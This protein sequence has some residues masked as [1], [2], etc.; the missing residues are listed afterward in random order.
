MNILICLERRRYGLILKLD[1]DATSY[2]QGEGRPRI[3][4]NQTLQLV[5]KLS[6]W[7]DN[8]TTVIHLVGWQGSGHDT[9]YLPLS[10]RLIA[11]S[12]V[13]HRHKSIE[14]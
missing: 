3:S 10:L 11:F 4:F 6:E 7:T 14:V 13:S 1:S 9:L 8:T 12:V 2:A 5:R